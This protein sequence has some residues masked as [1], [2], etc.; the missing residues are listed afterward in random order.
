[1]KQAQA[2]ILKAKSS[3]QQ[4]VPVTTTEPAVVTSG[5]EGGG[6]AV[7]AGGDQASG[8]RLAGCLIS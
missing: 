6:L 3:E 4:N 7:G 1:M 8:G 2:K 5:S